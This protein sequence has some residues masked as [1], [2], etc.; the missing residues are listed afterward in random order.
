LIKRKIACTFGKKMIV[1]TQTIPSEVAQP[2]W[3][4]LQLQ[5][6]KLYAMK[7]S[8]EDLIAIQRMIA[9][10]FAQK[11]SSEAQEAWDEAGYSEDLLL[12]EHIRTPYK[13]DQPFSHQSK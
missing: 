7:V 13:G 4:N 9:R 1:A 3:S 6:L 10:Y 11:A 5:L 12:Q 2:A 8:E